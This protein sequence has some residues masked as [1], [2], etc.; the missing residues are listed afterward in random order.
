[1]KVNGGTIIGVHF[2][3]LKGIGKRPWRYDT[4]PNCM[5]SKLYFVVGVVVIGSHCCSRD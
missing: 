3:G 1:L 2:C 5:V 4:N